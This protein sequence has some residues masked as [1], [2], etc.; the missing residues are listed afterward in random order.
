VA[1]SDRGPSGEAFTATVAVL[2]PELENHVVAGSAKARDGT[3]ACVWDFRTRNARIDTIEHDVLDGVGYRNWSDADARSLA[4]P[5]HATIEPLRVCVSCMPVKD[6]C[7]AA[8]RSLVT[9]ERQLAA[10]KA[11]AE[12]GGI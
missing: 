12:P 1:P 6:G 3:P 4:E 10:R 9:I 2:L 7:A 5:L 11:I 8:A